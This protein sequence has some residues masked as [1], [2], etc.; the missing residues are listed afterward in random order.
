MKKIILLLFVSMIIFLFSKDGVTKTSKK[1]FFE[2]GVEHYLNG[3]L[4]SAVK[5][6]RKAHSKDMSNIRKKHLLRNGLMILGKYALKDEDYSS[7][8]KYFK[9]ANKLIP[10]KVTMQL[11][12]LSEMEE[13][14]HTGKDLIPAEELN[15]EEEEKNITKLIFMPE[16][17]KIEKK[18]SG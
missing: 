10:N 3:E 16:E 1:D 4:E 14:F 8:V 7:A 13:K 15:T 17:T 5:K 9:E 6:W 2:T 18:N 11:V 12:S